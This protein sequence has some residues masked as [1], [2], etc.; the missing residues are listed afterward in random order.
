MA[1]LDGEWDVGLGIRKRIEGPRGWTR[2]GPLPGVPFAVHGRE[3]RY[4]W[5]PPLVDVLE[6]AADGWRGRA[7]LFGRTLF[8]FRMRRR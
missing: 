1:E 5:F 8:G 3:L 2:L 7:T 4:R 6:P